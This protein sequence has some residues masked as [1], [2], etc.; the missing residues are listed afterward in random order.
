VVHGAASDGTSG[1]AG[2]RRRRLRLQHELDGTVLLRDVS[3]R[4]QD[5]LVFFE[6]K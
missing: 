5:T 1:R 4:R 2:S 3:L 6:K